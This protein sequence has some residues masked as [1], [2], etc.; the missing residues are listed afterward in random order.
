MRIT[1]A[2]VPAQLRERH[3]HIMDAAT[4]LEAPRVL[5]LTVLIIVCFDLGYAAIGQTVTP[6]YYLSDFLQSTVMLVAAVGMRRGF[7]PERFA[8]SAF[9]AGVVAN[10]VATTYQ[11]TVVGEGALGVVALLLA[12]SGAVAL[13]WRSFLVGALFCTSWTGFVLYRTENAIWQTWYVTM[14]TAAAVAAAVLYGRSK[15]L[16]QL[17]SAQETIE[18]MATI[19]QLTGLLNRHGLHGQLHVLSAQARRAGQPV[20]VVFIDVSGLKQVNNRFGHFCGDLVLGRVAASIKLHAR[21]GELMCRWGGD[22]FVLIGV[23]DAP[24]PCNIAD[25][26]VAGIDPVGLEDFWTPRL[27]VGS[28]QGPV[29]DQGIDAIITAADHDM[30]RRRGGLEETQPAAV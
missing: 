29:T 6:G 28:A 13:R 27:W 25:R 30:L 15:S 18:R 23:G 17:A 1:P 4:A 20:F 14:V 2:T 21:S 19:D 3:R 5:F 7:I 24:D 16:L 22:E 10:N 12:I 9:I 11:A 26:L 8:P